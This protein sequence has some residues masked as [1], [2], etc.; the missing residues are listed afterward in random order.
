VDS[1]S[2][3]DDNETQFFPNI[4]EVIQDSAL[5]SREESVEW[6]SQ[7]FRLPV[8]MKEAMEEICRGHG[9]TPS[10]FLRKCCESLVRDYLPQARG[11]S[12]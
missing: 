6:S 9:T 10:M 3:K 7:S 1:T 8:P 4:H 12:Q 11:V 2:S 5:E